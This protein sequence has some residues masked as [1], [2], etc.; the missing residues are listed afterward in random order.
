MFKSR[1][2]LEYLTG[3]DVISTCGN[4]LCF[5]RLLNTGLHHSE[6]KTKKRED[7]AFYKF[8]FLQR[9]FDLSFSALF[10]FQG[11]THLEGFNLEPLLH[12]F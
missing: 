7:E 2:P 9:K 3:Q 1:K 11:T 6:L 10:I 4:M 12:Y 8:N 5:H